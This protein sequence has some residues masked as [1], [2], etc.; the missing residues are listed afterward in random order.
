MYQQHRLC[1]QASEHQENLPRQ[2]VIVLFKI[3]QTLSWG[4]TAQQKKTRQSTCLNA[5]PAEG[6]GAWD[7]AQHNGCVQGPF[8]WPHPPDGPACFRVRGLKRMHFLCS[9]LV[10]RFYLPVKDLPIPE[11]SITFGAILEESLFKNSKWIF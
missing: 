7:G 11:E 8:W 1:S 6:L 4:E 5:A 2:L 10:C 3:C 9:V